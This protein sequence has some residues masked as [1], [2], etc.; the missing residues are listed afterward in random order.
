VKISTTCTVHV[1]KAF[2]PCT[3]KQYESELS[4]FFLAGPSNGRVPAAGKLQH[5]NPKNIV[6]VP[7]YMRRV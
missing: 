2:L 1:S 6:P 3:Q 7:I 4:I 5:K